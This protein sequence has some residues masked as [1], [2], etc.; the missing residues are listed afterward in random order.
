MASPLPR[1]SPR[2]SSAASVDA[3]VKSPFGDLT[4]VEGAAVDAPVKSPLVPPPPPPL[5]PSVAGTPFNAD[6]LAPDTPVAQAPEPLAA[7]STMASEQGL[8]SPR[9]LRAKLAAVGQQLL[10]AQE[11]AP[12]SHFILA[13]GQVAF[14]LAAFTDVP[15]LNLSAWGGLLY[16]LGG[17][18]ASALG[19]QGSARVPVT[20]ADLRPQLEQLVA[21]MNRAMQLHHAIFRCSEPRQALKCAA[22]L[23]ALTILSARLPAILLAW[24]AFTLSFVVPK[25]AM[26]FEPQLAAA[27]ATVVAKMIDIN[28]RLEEKC[29]K[30]YALPVLALLWITYSSYSTMALTL[31]VGCIGVQ[32]WHASDPLASA[33][34]KELSAKSAAGFDQIKKRARRLTISAKDMMRGKPEDAKEE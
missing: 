20:E 16:L 5:T 17:G 11:E 32:A 14:A 18:V 23:Y 8:L 4:N 3:P 22:A 29:P 25:F 28:G 33:E 31:G 30:K 13:G 34:F 26:H 10:Q 27:K 19:K 7:P 12:H 6:D 15:M 21:L 9:L 24:A 2:R 1:S